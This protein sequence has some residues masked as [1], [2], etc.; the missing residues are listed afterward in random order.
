MSRYNIY[1]KRLDAAF[2][3]ARKQYTDAYDAVK[4]K[5]ANFKKVATQQGK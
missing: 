2:K 5:A 3:D 1:A 4:E